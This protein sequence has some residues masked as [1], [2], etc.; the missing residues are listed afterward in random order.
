MHFDRALAEGRDDV[1]TSI[2]R[3]VE[4]PFGNALAPLGHWA[5]LHEA[6]RRQGW[7]Q[8]RQVRFPLRTL[9][10]AGAR[11]VAVAMDAAGLAGLR[12]SR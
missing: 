8:S 1:A 9:D 7:F 12:Y 11:A 3:D 2:V 5:A 4:Q 10:E 6:L